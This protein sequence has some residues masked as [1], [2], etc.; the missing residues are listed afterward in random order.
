MSRT[1]LA[2]FPLSQFKFFSGTSGGNSTWSATP[3]R[4]G[5]SYD[6]RFFRSLRCP[7]SSNAS[8]GS[9]LIEACSATQRRW[10][11]H[12]L[13]VSKSG[14]VQGCPWQTCPRSRGGLHP[15]A[16]TTRWVRGTTKVAWARRR[17][18]LASRMT[19]TCGTSW[20]WS[21]FDELL[22]SP[23]SRGRLIRSGSPSSRSPTPTRRP[24]LGASFLAAKSS[25]AA[26]L[27]LRPWC[28][29]TSRRL[30]R[31]SSASIPPAS[32]R[33][34]R[35]VL[36]SSFLVRHLTFHQ[37]SLSSGT[38]LLPTPSSSMAIRQTAAQRTRWYRSS[39][40]PSSR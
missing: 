2:L 18:G 17:P 32:T 6:C 3:M 27:A 8:L 10:R 19:R 34:Q 29:S 15:F 36:M 13:E 26:A 25:P 40:L 4:A 20:I 30:R 35:F 9:A 24:G 16:T 33:S 23:S 5:S 37:S 38:S 21:R 7:R 11:G 1:M 28:A 39:T 12:S 31:A 14:R 22:G